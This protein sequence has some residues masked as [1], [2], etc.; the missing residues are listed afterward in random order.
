MAMV[1]TAIENLN[2]FWVVGVVEQYKGFV[3]VLR[4]TLDPG[5][6]HGDLWEHAVEVKNNGQ[7]NVNYFLFFRVR[8]A[9][10]TTLSE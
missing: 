9:S 7:V 3:E 1:A 4:R 8:L 6:K 10:S 2:E 5:M